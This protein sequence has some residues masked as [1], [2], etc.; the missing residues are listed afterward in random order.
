MA[1]FST[2]TRAEN[3][4]ADAAGQLKATIDFAVVRA[5]RTT[6]Q[7]PTAFAPNPVLLGPSG[8]R[9][10]AVREDRAGRRVSRSQ[11]WS[12]GCTRSFVAA[13]AS[14]RVTENG[15]AEGVPSP[16]TTLKETKPPD[17]AGAETFD[18]YEWQATMAAADVFAAYLGCLDEHGVLRGDLTFE[19]ICEHHEDWALSDGH[20]TEIVSGKHRETQVGAFTT[21]YSLLVEGGVLHLLDRWLALGRTPKCRLV[22]TAGVAGDARA[23]MEAA[24]AFAI[25]KRAIH[26]GAPD[27]WFLSGHRRCWL[28][29]SR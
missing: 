13:L 20:G 24:E 28:G 3:H 19:V 1:P 22:T 29:L 11:A 25:G 7:R 18:R 15:G 2:A 10:L 17:D 4:G 21:V 23:L 6:E 5:E 8:S 26:L 16:V 9:Q 27:V 14:V 12:T